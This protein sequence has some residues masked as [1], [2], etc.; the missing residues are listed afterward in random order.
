MGV[1]AQHAAILRAVAALLRADAPKLIAL[2]PTVVAALPTAAGG[3]RLPDG[4][5]TAFIGGSGSG[6]KVV[7]L[8]G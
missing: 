6:S 7:S 2:S 1:E 4:L 5:P 3:R 8:Q